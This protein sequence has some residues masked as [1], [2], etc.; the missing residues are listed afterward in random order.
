MYPFGPP[1]N[2]IKFKLCI[3]VN[4]ILPAPPHPVT[5]HKSI[6]YFFPSTPALANRLIS[7]IFLCS[8]FMC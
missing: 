1:E 5:G 2:R 8:I 7:T 6:L 4:E 3:Y